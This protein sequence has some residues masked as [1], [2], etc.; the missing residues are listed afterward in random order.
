MPLS[1]RTLLTATA[2]VITVA[3]CARPRFTAIT[4]V[5]AA[6][7]ERTRMLLSALA[8]DSME[9]RGTG[10]RGSMRA[11][12]FI[13]ATMRDAGLEPA[14]D[15][16]YFQRVPMARAAGAYTGRLRPVL[17]SSLSA[18]DTIPPDRHLTGGN[19][20]GII[21]G[22]DGQLTNEVVLVDAHYD[23]EGI[24]PAVNGDSIYNGADDDA[25]GTIAVMEIA[26]IIAAGPRPKRTVIFLATTGEELGLLGTRWYIASP[27]RP[28][29]AHV[30]N[31]EIEMIGRP[32]SLAGGPGRGWL[33][34]YERS[35][36]G[37]MFAAEG[38]PIG[39]DKRPDQRFF[40]R[41]DNIAFA[42]RGI[43]AHTLSSYNMHGEYHTPADEV[44][45][46]DFDHMAAVIN[47]AARAVR[48]LADGP[49]VEWKPG[50]KP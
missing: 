46:V 25:S 31:L 39:P 48:L 43:V 42:R 11:A 23:H 47:A 37:D 9:G 29:E 35:T 6:S 17:L 40:E 36:M 45:L 13:A 7:A 27:V 14:G 41:S 50:G 28:L 16:G 5:A 44:R 12:R 49:R 4:P 15:S 3:S 1:Q 26:R 24:G 22:A 20:V 32:D 38:L 2:L 34:G 33:T 10:T 21:R 30:A 8:D 18:L 19:V